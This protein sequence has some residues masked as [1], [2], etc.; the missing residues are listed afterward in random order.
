MNSGMIAI[1]KDEKISIFNQQA[2]D[3]LNLDPSR[4]IGRDLRTLPSPLGDILYET[5][6]TGTSYKRFEATVHPMKMPLGINSYRLLDEQEKPIGA[7]IMFSD[8]SDSKKLEEQRRRTEQLKAVNDIMAKIAH[9]VRNPLTSI[10]TYTQLLNDKY[11]DED[12]GKFYVSTVSQ[13]IRRLDDL[14]DK[15]ITFSSTQE[16]NFCKENIN[17]IM[18]DASEF[19]SKNIPETH[20]FS[21]QL[22]EESLFVNADRKH[23][24]KGIY[25]LI[26]SIID[27]SPDGTFISMNARTVSGEKALVVLAITYGTDKKG[28]E[29][30]QNLLKPL[31][32]IHHLGTELNVPISNKIIEGHDGSLDIIQEDDLNTFVI[33]LPLLEGQSDSN[34][35]KE[36][37]ERGRQRKNSGN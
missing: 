11:P 30:D 4:I 1:D 15:L 31:L 35:I 7:G 37:E 27:R 21:K 6:V 10:Q 5:M 25:Y 34:S 23:L 29:G 20:K 16:Y 3:V 36:G 19:I 32:D 26:Q 28:K 9:E 2:A 17:D 18:R 33:R 24:I 13:S 14:I 22:M 12:L 8:L